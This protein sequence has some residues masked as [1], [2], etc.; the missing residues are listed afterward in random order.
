MRIESRQWLYDAEEM[1]GAPVNGG[2][3]QKPWRK[4]SVIKEMNI[5]YT[6]TNYP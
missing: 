6:V 3:F 1:N 4:L 2:K 5:G